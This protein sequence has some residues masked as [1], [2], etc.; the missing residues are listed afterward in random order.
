MPPYVLEVAPARTGGYAASIST[1]DTVLIDGVYGDTE[2]EAA[3]TAAANSLPD[4]DQN[5]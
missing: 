4:T 2:A 1:A 3:M 5:G